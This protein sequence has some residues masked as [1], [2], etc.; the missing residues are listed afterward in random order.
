MERILEP[1]TILK[2]VQTWV[3]DV[4]ETWNLNAVGLFVHFFFLSQIS[5]TTSSLSISLVH[6]KVHRDTSR[7]KIQNVAVFR[8]MQQA[9]FSCFLVQTGW[10]S[11]GK[12]GS[13]FQ[14]KTMSRHS[15]WSLV[16]R[17]MNEQIKSQLFYCLE[18]EYRS[19]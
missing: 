8:Q 9:C 16:C 12:E 6:T 13:N 10:Q 19:I 2:Q 7:N 1:Y 15:H 3:S 5:L 17:R 18:P 11:L 4:S 14:K